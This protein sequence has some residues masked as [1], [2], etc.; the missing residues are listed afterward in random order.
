M[1][2][3]CGGGPWGHQGVWMWW[4]PVGPPE[5]LDVVVARAATRVFGC[6]GGP[7]GHQSVWMWW[8]PVGPP[9]C[10]DVVVALGATK[11]SLG[12]VMALV[13][14]CRCLAVMEADA[15]FQSCW[16]WWWSLGPPTAWLCC[17]FLRPSDLELAILVTRGATGASWMFDSSTWVSLVYGPCGFFFCCVW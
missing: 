5:G 15:P 17:F 16:V 9:E 7:W 4:W 10:L 8:W 12:V 14:H 1:A 11:L 6:G 2:V 3:G 13:G